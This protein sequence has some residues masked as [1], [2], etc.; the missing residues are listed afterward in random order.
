MTKTKNSGMAIHLHH[1]ILFEWCWGFKERI[2]VIDTEKPEHERATRK[3][4]F[5]FLT[6]KE[7]DMLPIDFVEVCKAYGE[8]NQ[9][10]KETYQKWKEIYQKWKEIY[11]KRR[12]ANQ[13]FRETYQKRREAVQKYKPQLEEIHKKICGCK[14]WNGEGL[15]FPE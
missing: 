15:V 10:W 14:E 9:K 8:A 5:R 13:K 11:Q 3:R 1:N 2:N 4:L 7:I 6:K 12:E